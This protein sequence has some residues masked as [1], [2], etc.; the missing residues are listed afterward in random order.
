MK[1]QDLISLNK[2]EDMMGLYFIAK[3]SNGE[4]VYQDNR[5]ND[6]HAWLR[7]NDF[8]K[9]NPELKI[10]S[11]EIIKK[12]GKMYKSPENQSGYCF[13]LKKT[14][15]YLAPGGEMDSVCYGHY[16]GEFCYITWLNSNGKVVSREKRTKQGAGF[17]LICNE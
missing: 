9:A 14:K 3:L 10:I 17:F 12:N 7:L 4:T 6:R 13:G 1:K 11:L 15:V 16:D 8:L 5:K 2:Q